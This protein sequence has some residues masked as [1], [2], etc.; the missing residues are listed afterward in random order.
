MISKLI[1]MLSLTVLPIALISCS[2]SSN[3]NINN[4]SKEIQ[5][6]NKTEG[7]VNLNKSIYDLSVK[8]MDG[9]TKEMSD[10]NGKVILIV[11]VA[12]ECGF[13]VQYEGLERVYIVIMV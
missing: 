4:Q 10:Y 5:V 2:R 7:N 13:T 6:K 9:G 3:Q 12:S 11:N 8:T 1:F